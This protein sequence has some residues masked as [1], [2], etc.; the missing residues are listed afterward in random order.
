MIMKSYD[1]MLACYTNATVHLQSLHI[2]KE[3]NMKLPTFCPGC[4]N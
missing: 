3:K 2:F 1:D 4:I